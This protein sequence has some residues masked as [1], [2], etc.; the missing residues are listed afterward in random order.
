MPCQG[1]LVAFLHCC[2]KLGLQEGRKHI[3]S[4][5]ESCKS[6]QHAIMKYR[7]PSHVSYFCSLWQP[8]V[9]STGICRP[10][11]EGR[12][13]KRNNFCTG[14][15]SDRR[16][17]DRCASCTSVT[18]CFGTEVT[19]WERGAGVKHAPKARLLGSAQ[20][21]DTSG[22]YCRRYESSGPMICIQHVLLPL[23]L[24]NHKQCGN[25]V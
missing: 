18:V 23:N 8:T 15:G 13:E 9:H 25:S 1:S 10:K 6:R 3:P 17:L 4:A 24:S 2:R 12:R 20:N 16:V 14:R 21:L 11:L 5:Q 7:R 22:S 19:R